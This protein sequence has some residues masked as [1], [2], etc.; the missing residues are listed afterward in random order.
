MGRMT[1]WMFW[2]GLMVLFGAGLLFG[3][4]VAHAEAGEEWVLWARMWSASPGSAM[5][6]HDTWQRHVTYTNLDQCER[7]YP[8]RP[9][10]DTGQSSH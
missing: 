8:P 4:A 10:L 7:D 1:N 2:M 3:L 6:P 9:R 5:K